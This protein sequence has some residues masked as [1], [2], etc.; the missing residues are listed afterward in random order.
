MSPHADK[1]DEPQGNFLTSRAGLVVLG[2]L[3]VAGLLLLT[4]HRAHVLGALLWILPFACLLM[5]M[6]MHGGAHGGY[7]GHGSSHRERNVP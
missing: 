7:G 4:E 6:F 2:F 1:R 3:A 5:H